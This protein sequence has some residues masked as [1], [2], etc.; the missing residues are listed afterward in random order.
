MQTF[1]PN[2]KSLHAAYYLMRKIVVAEEAG[3]LDEFHN[4]LMSTGLNTILSVAG[5]PAVVLA[6]MDVT[7]NDLSSGR[8][9]FR[10]QC[11]NG[12]RV[13]MAT[14]EPTISGRLL[15]LC[16]VSIIHRFNSL[17]WFTAIREH[18]SGASTMVK[19]EEDGEND[20]SRADTFQ[21]ILALEV[22]WVSLWSFHRTAGFTAA[23]Y[24]VVVDELSSRRGLGVECMLLM[25]IARDSCR[26]RLRHH[27]RREPRLV[28]KQA[29]L[30]LG[31][32]AHEC[33]GQARVS[34]ASLEACSYLHY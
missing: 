24:L 17:A 20:A 6:S 15:D 34:I 30:I 21:R 31:R 10:V 7:R 33:D 18:L 22:R 12:I 16:S 26:Q 1:S 5:Q 2:H 3:R 23:K 4:F 13:I 28:T 14:Q 27:H 11:H 25:G 32:T 8:D 9:G 29:L 19:S